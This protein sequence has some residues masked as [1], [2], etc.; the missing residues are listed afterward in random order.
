[1]L[2]LRPIG[3]DDY[4]VREGGQTIGRIRYAS[5][6]SPGIWLWNIQVHVTT[7]LPMSS[8][9]DLESAKTEFKAAWESLKVRVGPEALARAFAAMNIRDGG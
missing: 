6:R 7:G 8:A 1:M 4:N 3:Q 5:E 9:K 2:T